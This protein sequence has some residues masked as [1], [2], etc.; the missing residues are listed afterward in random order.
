MEAEDNGVPEGDLREARATCETHLG[1]HWVRL[2]AAL[3]DGS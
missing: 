2:V 3:A 1:E